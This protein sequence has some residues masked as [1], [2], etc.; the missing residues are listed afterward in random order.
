[1]IHPVLARIEGD[2]SGTRG[3]SI[4]IVP[5]FLVN[6]DGS[7]GAF[8]DV[9]CAGIEHKMGIKGTATCQLSFGDNGNCT[10]FLLWRRAS[11]A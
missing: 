8:N 1:M 11:G 3:I 10:R 7:L 4:F 5:K 9:T 2:P 6:A